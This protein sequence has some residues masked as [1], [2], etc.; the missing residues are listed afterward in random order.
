MNIRKDKDIDD[1]LWR[2]LFQENLPKARRSPWFTRKVMNRLPER[3]R[4]AIS[5]IEW[6]GGAIAAIVL[7]VYW[8]VFSRDIVQSHV[9]TLKDITMISVLSFMTLTL[10][11]VF[12]V[13]LLRRV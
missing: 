5:I 12:A 11:G 13:N 6:I 4:P 10:I 7:L 2:E 1:K 3:K 9:I 8:I